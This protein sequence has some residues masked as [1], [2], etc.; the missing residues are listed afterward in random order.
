MT[1]ERFKNVPL[2]PEDAMMNIEAL[3]NAS[4]FMGFV[5]EEETMVEVLTLASDY[6]AAVRKNNTMGGG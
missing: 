2:H 3:V 5:N 1:N 6:V 4:L